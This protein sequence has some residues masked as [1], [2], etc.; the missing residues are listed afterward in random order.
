MKSSVAGA[1]KSCVTTVRQVRGSDRVA[2]CRSVVVA[3]LSGA[4][5]SSWAHED[6]TPFRL[7]CIA[8]PELTQSTASSASSTTCTATPR[9][10]S[11]AMS[12]ENPSAVP[13]DLD[14]SSTS[15]VTKHTGPSDDRPLIEVDARKTRKNCNNKNRATDTSS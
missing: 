2:Q 8:F 6:V 3:A 13:R 4:V 10:E 14:T 1:Q 7:S 9:E 5:A 15:P 11:D 12:C